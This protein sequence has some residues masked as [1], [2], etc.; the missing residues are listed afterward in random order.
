MAPGDGPG[1]ESVYSTII[2][3]KF[4]EFGDGVSSVNEEKQNPY[5]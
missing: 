5:Q 1:A 2:R 4:G 3:I